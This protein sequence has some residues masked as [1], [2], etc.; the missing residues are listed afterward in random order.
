MKKQHIKLS[1][2]DK[3]TI[4][5]ILSKGSQKVIKYKRATALK[6]LDAGKTCTEAHQ[7]VGCSDLTMLK[8][9]NHYNTHGLS[10]LEDKP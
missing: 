1:E 4:E 7:I 5:E 9:R 3:T 8:W 6:L 10:F 2:S